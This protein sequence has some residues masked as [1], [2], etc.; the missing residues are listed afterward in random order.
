MRLAGRDSPCPATE[1]AAQDLVERMLH[2]GE[3]LGGIIVLVV[4]VYVIV[5]DSR[6]GLGR[7]EVVVHKGFGGLAGEL[8]HHARRG[9]GVHVGVLPSDVVVLGLDNLQ[10]HVTGTGLAGNRT[11]VTVSDVT[12]G[13]L[14]ARRLHQLYLHAVLNLL[15]GHAL[16]PGDTYPVGDAL[17]QRLV[18]SG[19]GGE[20]SLAY[21]R[22][23]FLF[24]VADH[25]AISFDYC[26]Y[27]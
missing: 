18:L 12:L 6:L 3:R 8:H 7:E 27:H 20:H 26:L 25:A 23:Y 22:L 16:R 19:L 11:L 17:N 13:H 24:V 4:Y 21:G 14:L 15:H 2:A 5:A 1:A 9:V 10:E